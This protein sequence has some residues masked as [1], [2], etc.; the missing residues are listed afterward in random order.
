MKKTFFYLFVLLFGSLFFVSC[1]QKDPENV[2]DKPDSV[3]LPEGTVYLQALNSEYRTGADMGYSNASHSFL[4]MFATE[5]CEVVKGQAFGNGGV[6]VLEMCSRSAENILPAEGV[7]PIKDMEPIEDDMI[8]GGF[9]VGLDSPFG[10]YMWNMVDD[11]FVGFD[12]II[13][14]GV[15]IKKT[16]KP[17]ELEFIIYTVSADGK[18]GYYYYKGELLIANLSSGN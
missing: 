14:G 17:N 12:L 1:E 9:D 8:I 2:E 16:D 5:E 10:T 4:L 13:G 6:L 3:V 11:E 18:E 15:E 7:Y